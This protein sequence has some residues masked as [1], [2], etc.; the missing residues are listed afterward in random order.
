MSAPMEG[1]SGSHRKLILKLLTFVVFMGVFSYLLVPFYN[2]LCQALGINGKTNATAAAYDSS[3]I[4]DKSR[5]IT[6]QL[7]ATNNAEM[8]W[9]FHPT[10][11]QVTIHPGENKLVAY[12]A[13]NNADHD[14]VAQAIPSVA[15]AEAAPY[16][17]KTQCFCFE[18]QP[19]GQGK[20]AEM[21]ILFHVTPEIPKHIHTITLSYTLF[22]AGKYAKTK[23]RKGGKIS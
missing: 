17:K 12:Y 8:P 20:S 21:P 18:Q 11:K 4:I 19:L 10:V 2:V 6:I 14:M 9:D 23:Q 3:Q 1:T 13:K 5:T 7:L 22:D 15:P 16:L